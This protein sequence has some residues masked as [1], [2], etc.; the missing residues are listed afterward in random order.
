MCALQINKSNQDGKICIST[1]LSTVNRITREML[2]LFLVMKTRTNVYI[3]PNTEKEAN[4]RR[5][6][7]AW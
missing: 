5:Y 3:S 1:E 6:D 2:T 7:A 4:Q